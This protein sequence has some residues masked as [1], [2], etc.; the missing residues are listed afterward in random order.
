VSCI[1]ACKRLALF[2]TALVLF[3]FGPWPSLPLARPAP[4]SCLQPYL[5]ACAAAFSSLSG[6]NLPA[7]TFYA[8]A[9][10]AQPC[11][12]RPSFAQPCWAQLC[13]HLPRWAQACRAGPRPAALSSGLSLACPCCSLAANA[14]GAVFYSVPHFGAKL[15]AY[16]WQLRYVGGSPAAAVEQLRPGPHLDQIN[17]CVKVGGT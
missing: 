8:E 1:S 13:A 5:Q 17:S 14:R 6:A 11:R 10:P 7:Q 2:I 12:A 4:L 3:V 16:G 15:A 9:S